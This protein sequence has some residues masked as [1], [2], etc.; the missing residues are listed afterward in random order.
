VQQML[1]E[2]LGFDGVILSDDLEMKAISN[3]MPV[4]AA[5][6]QAIQAGC[7]GVLVCSGN[8]ETQAATLEALVKAAESGEI[9]P[10]RLDDAFARLRRAKVRFLA[11]ERPQ[12]STR[13]RGLRAVI[14][15]DEHQA[16]AAE[17][18]AFL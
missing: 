16:I 10:A 3:R 11:R 5:A 6:V 1:R 8:V 2:E 13:I 18:A 4:P 17:M 12:T 14:G 7:D 9:R 15:R